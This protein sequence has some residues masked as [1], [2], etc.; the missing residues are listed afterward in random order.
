MPSYFPD[1]GKGHRVSSQRLEF[2]SYIYMNCPAFGK[3]LQVSELI[4]I[5]IKRKGDV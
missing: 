5:K 1:A 4:D 2:K 3:A